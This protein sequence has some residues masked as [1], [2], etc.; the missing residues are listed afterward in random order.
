M[1]RELSEKNGFKIVRDREVNEKQDQ[2]RIRAIYFGT[3]LKIFGR[4]KNDFED[5][6][7][8]HC[9]TSKDGHYN[10]TTVRFAPKNGVY[11][12]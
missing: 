12:P 7:N 11:E 1:E 3:F 2:T 8:E 10:S 6:G 9:V 5:L 4:K